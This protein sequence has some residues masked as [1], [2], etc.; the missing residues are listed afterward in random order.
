MGRRRTGGL[1]VRVLAD[2]TRAFHLRFRVDGRRE[3]LVLH[4]RAGC[5]C[6]CGGSWEQQAARAELGN[7]EAKIHLGIWRRPE[8]PILAESSREE[9]G[10]PLFADYA[11]WWLEAKIDGV[12]GDRPIS[13]STAN[14]YRWR[15]QRHLLPFFG[16]FAVDRIDRKLC[17]DF[18]ARLLRQ[19]RELREA[20]DEGTDIRDHRGRRAVPLGPASI[21]KILD[22]LAAVLDD[23]IEDEHIPVKSGSN[24]TL[25]AR[26]RTDPHCTRLG[27]ASPRAYACSGLR[28][29]GGFA[30]RRRNRLDPLVLE[31]VALA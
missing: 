3:R 4:E 22:C 24:L 2:G 30:L 18:K 21:R 14:D 12:L 25:F 8:Q 26:F 19:A 16:N 20:L 1:E 9:G 31:P 6:G 7:I 5:A 28:V 13:E 10:V 23:A 29:S 27:R 15:L 17:L 11:T